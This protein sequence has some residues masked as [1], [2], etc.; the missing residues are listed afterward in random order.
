MPH[1]ALS[2][3]PSADNRSSKAPKY[4]SPPLRHADTAPLLRLHR[5]ARLL[6]LFCGVAVAPLKSSPSL[7]PF[8]SMSQGGEEN[9]YIYKRKVM[10]ASSFLAGHPDL[11]FREDRSNKSETKWLIEQ[12]FV[13][14]NL[15]FVSQGKRGGGGGGEMKSPIKALMA[16]FRLSQTLS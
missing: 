11:H 4:L 14:H 6:N 8:H 12:P 1:P 2:L 3:N 10:Y 13:K 7:L 5:D 16:F 9:S 15:V